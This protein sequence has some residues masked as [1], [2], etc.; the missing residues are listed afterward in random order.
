M[1]PHTYLCPNKAVLREIAVK[2]VSSKDNGRHA[3]FLHLTFSF[4]WVNQRCH[5]IRHHGYAHHY[6]PLNAVF[7]KK[8]QDLKEGARLWKWFSLAK[9]KQIK[10]TKVLHLNTSIPI[11][12][13]WAGKKKVWCLIWAMKIPSEILALPGHEMSFPIEWKAREDVG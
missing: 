3:W 4:T 5:D 13:V 12:N 10:P 6:Q 1:W 8:I 2:T 11:C 9:N 7:G